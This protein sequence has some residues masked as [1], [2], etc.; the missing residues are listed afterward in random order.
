[1]KRLRKNAKNVDTT[2]LTRRAINDLLGRAASPDATRADLEEIGDRLFRIGDSIVPALVRRL[3]ETDDDEALGRYAFLV[4]YLDNEAFVDPLVD[5]LLSRRKSD[6]AKA[7]LLAAL[8]AYNVDTSD[9]LFADIFDRPGEALA[10]SASRLVEEAEAAVE[11]PVRFLEHFSGYTRAHK[12][13]IVAELGKLE[14][15]RAIRYLELLAEHEDEEVATLAIDTLGRVRDARAVTALARLAHGHPVPAR[16]A[17]AERGLRRLSFAGFPVD[18][19][20]RRIVPPPRLGPLYKVHVSRIDG[21][22]GR[23][24]WFARRRRE[25]GPDLMAVCL[26]VDDEVGLKDGF[27]YEEIERA[28]YESLLRKA[29]KEEM[30]VES[31]FRYAVTLLRDALARNAATDTPYPPHFPLL[32]R[33]FEAT[34]LTAAAY[35]PAFPE[36]GDA[37]L[38]DDLATLAETGSLLDRD[39]FEG[40]LLATERVYDYAD[41]VRGLADA[42]SR[43][44]FVRKSL[45]VH[46]RFFEELV[47]P[48][49]PRYRD[50]LRLTAD[51]LR[52]VG[53]RRRDVRL[54]LAAAAHIDAAV[55]RRPRVPAT[56]QPFVHRLIFESLDLAVTALN[57]GYD[58]RKDADTE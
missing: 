37:A 57:D 43:R 12:L 40:W 46:H 25:E 55:E 48:L 58:L 54:A 4:E 52:R 44:A 7:S 14:D 13:V 5:L 15:R 1:M 11:S 22:G 20:R 28:D 29:R 45:S 9:P 23:A 2:L 6:R 24:L 42:E 35:R 26:L 21:Q 32:R 27:G 50:R 3:E 10:H 49:M 34:D 47:R 51:L 16:R 18:T 38:L 39:E 17:R 41:E 53:N 19:V 56:D 30:L 8:Q 31:D 36:F 33:F